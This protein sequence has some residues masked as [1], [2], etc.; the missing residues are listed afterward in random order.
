VHIVFIMVDFR[1]LTVTNSVKSAGM[2]RTPGASRSRMRVG[3]GEAFGV[4]RFPPLCWVGGNTGETVLACEQAAK[5]VSQNLR[6]A[7]GSKIGCSADFPVC[8]IASRKAGLTRGR[9]EQF[10]TLPT[11]KSAKQQAGKPALRHAA[12]A[13]P[14]RYEISGLRHWRG[15][16]LSNM[17][18]TYATKRTK[19]MNPL[20]TL[21]RPVMRKSLVR[22]CSGRAWLRPRRREGKAKRRPAVRV[23]FGP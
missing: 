2:P 11:G 18:M 22:M 4:R 12:V 6:K 14:Q 5:T 19:W 21:V 13:A 8:R 15:R 10:D 7:L 16:H 23:V 3:H 20:S 17:R 9:G 1:V